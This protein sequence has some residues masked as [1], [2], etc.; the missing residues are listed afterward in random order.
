LTV[1]S[2]SAPRSNRTLTVGEVA[3]ESLNPQNLPEDMD[4]GLIAGATF[5]GGELPDRLPYL[6]DRDRQG[7]R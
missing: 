3:K 6:R 7:D 5:S 4:L 2:F 1:A